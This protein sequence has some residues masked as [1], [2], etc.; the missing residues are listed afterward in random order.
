[1][2]NID[3]GIAPSGFYGSE[4]LSDAVK[5]NPLLN[6]FVLEAK[7][8]SPPGRMGGTVYWSIMG[9]NDLKELTKY[10]PNKKATFYERRS[11]D[12]GEEIHKKAL[13]KKIISGMS[14]DEMT[15]LF[16]KLLIKLLLD[17]I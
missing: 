6:F 11:L 4:E 5:K 12:S 3:S 2:E 1:M 15:K 8:N 13:A 14:E 16:E 10:L 9:T 17:G 7:S